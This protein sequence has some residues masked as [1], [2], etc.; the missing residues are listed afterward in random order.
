MD[1]AFVQLDFF[2]FF[3]V[4]FRNIKECGFCSVFF[5]V[6]MVLVQFRDISIINNVG[7]G[8]GGGVGGLIVGAATAVV[9]AMG[10]HH[11][12]H[13]A[14]YEHHNHGKY[15]RGLF[16]GGKYKRGKQSIGGGNYKCGKHGM[17]GG[18]R[19]KHDMF[20]GKRGKGMFGQRKW[21]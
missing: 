17:F 16:G 8:L 5:F 13:R 4:Q 10:G 11:V 6:N 14:G 2:F 7:L 3:W 1:V 9:A 19:G 20:G 15:I 12:G 18:K 21:K